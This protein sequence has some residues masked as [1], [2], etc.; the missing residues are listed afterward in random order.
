M[1]TENV[2]VKTTVI[3]LPSKSCMT[4]TSTQTHKHIQLLFIHLH[5]TKLHNLFMN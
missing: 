3:E 4:N 2:T 5:K 1:Q